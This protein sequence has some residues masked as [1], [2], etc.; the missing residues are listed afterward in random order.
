VRISETEN[1]R[2]SAMASVDLRFVTR[3]IEYL[4]T[5]NLEFLVTESRS[6][7]RQDLFVLAMLGF[8]RGRYFVEFGATDGIALSNTYALEKHFGWN[9]IVAEPAKM[10]HKALSRNRSCSIDQRAVWS[11]SGQR[12]EF[13]ETVVGA[14]STLERFS[15]SDLHAKVRASGRLYSVQTVSLSDLLDFHSAP[16]VIDYLS[17]DTEGSEAEILGSFDFSD[18]IF[19]V[20][21]VEHNFTKTRVAIKEVLEKNGYVRILE[22]LSSFDDWY[23]NRDHFEKSFLSALIETPKS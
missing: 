5:K 11:R 16:Q 15:S 14:V 4:P 8:P 7:L 9:G 1:Y 23:L 21:T 3:L 10:W 2:L 19:K 6:Q 13:N 12:L 17:I 20:I 22:D 18:Y